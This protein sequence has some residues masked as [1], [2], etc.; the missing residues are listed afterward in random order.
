MIEKICCNVETLLNKLFKSPSPH[1]VK[2]DDKGMSNLIFYYSNRHIYKSYFTKA[3]FFFIHVIL[4][5]RERFNESEIITLQEKKILVFNKKACLLLSLNSFCLI[6][7]QYERTR[8]DYNEPV[9]YRPCKDPCGFDYGV[10][11]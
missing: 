7:V 9:L 4:L 10:G 8:I 3:S 2:S 1:K 6:F 11:L 5:K